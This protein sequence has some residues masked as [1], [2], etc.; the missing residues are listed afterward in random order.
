MRALDVAI[1]KSNSANPNEKSS[2]LLLLEEMVMMGA[3][4]EVQ[5]K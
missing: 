1:A 3:D 5:I 4:E 2:T